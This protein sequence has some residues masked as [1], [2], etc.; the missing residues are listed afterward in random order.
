MSDYEHESWC[1]TR[2][3]IS[4]TCNCILG[5]PLEEIETLS[6]ALAENNQLLLK[7]ETAI[8]ECP[9]NALLLMDSGYDKKKATTKL[10]AWVDKYMV[11]LNGLREKKA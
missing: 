5:G 10:R 2:N 6:I 11:L 7:L 9:I 3:N 1:D 8:K 4:K